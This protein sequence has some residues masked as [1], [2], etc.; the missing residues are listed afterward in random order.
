M[1]TPNVI[2][3]ACAH[4]VIEGRPA[5]NIQMARA[6]TASTANPVQR[7][8]P[9]GTLGLES[10]PSGGSASASMD[11]PDN[12]ASPPSAERTLRKMMMICARVVT[13]KKAA[14][15]KMKGAVGSLR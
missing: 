8:L 11:Q 5:M 13:T 6:P 15:A 10:I 2:L 1:L 14:M 9:A 12:P 3:L 4:A 7:T